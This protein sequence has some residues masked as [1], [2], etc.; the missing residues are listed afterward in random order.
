MVS[1]S[2][3]GILKKERRKKKGGGR[4]ITVIQSSVL[5]RNHIHL[6]DI[7]MEPRLINCRWN[8]TERNEANERLQPAS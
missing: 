2:S 1:S 8:I 5:Q 3:E 7:T 6:E 4:E